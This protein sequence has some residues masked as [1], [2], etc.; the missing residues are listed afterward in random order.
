MMGGGVGGQTNGIRFL[1]PHRG[2]TASLSCPVLQLRWGSLGSSAPQASRHRPCHEPEGSPAAAVRACLRQSGTGSGR[3]WTPHPPAA[4]DV[5][6]ALRTQRSAGKPGEACGRTLWSPVTQVKAKNTLAFELRHKRI[7]RLPRGCAQPRFL[8][9][10]EAPALGPP[11]APRPGPH[12][13]L[14]PTLSP[15]LSS[16]ASLTLQDLSSSDLTGHFCRGLSPVRGDQQSQPDQPSHLFSRR[17]FLEGSPGNKGV[18]SDSS[19]PPISGRGPGPALSMEAPGMS[20]C[21]WA[22]PA[23]GSSAGGGVPGRSQG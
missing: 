17:G 18:R 10:P 16:L 13:A 19:C 4:T 1:H 22:P 6:G 9:V 2:L 12:G 7:Q 8:R 14:Q 11:P 21:F 15:P 5:P 20:L 23:R 3:Q